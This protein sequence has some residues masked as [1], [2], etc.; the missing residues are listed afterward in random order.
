VG[1]AGARLLDVDGWRFLEVERFD[2]VGL[3]GRRSVLSLMALANEE[4][5]PIDSWSSAA[6]ALRKRPRSLSEDDARQ[7]RWLDLFG[8]L[9]GNTDR[10]F[11]NVSFLVDE[12]GGLRLAPAYDMLPMALAPNGDEVLDRTPSVEPPSATNLDVWPDAARWATRY[13]QAVRAE[14][15][16]EPA[17]RAYAQ[18]AEAAIA[19]IAER[20]APAE[21][22]VGTGGCTLPG[23]HSESLP[24]G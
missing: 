23:P 15:T 20:V 13:W 5:G 14:P 16:L 21:Q 24:Q 7:L 9:I 3:R 10:H 2:R 18:A 11:G 8:H 22:S 12:G 17:V 1:A 4:L 6:P 19:R